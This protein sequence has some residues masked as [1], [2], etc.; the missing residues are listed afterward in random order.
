MTFE[1]PQFGVF[2]LDAGGNCYDAKADW[3][4]ISVNLTIPAGG[5]VEMERSLATAR[6]LWADQK[7]WQKRI[8]DCAIAELWELKNESWLG[9][10]EAEVTAAEFA[11]RMQLQTVSVDADGL[12]DFWH[13]DG[14]LFWGHVITVAG[15]LDDGPTGADIYG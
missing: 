15:S 6:N 7:N 3:G 13:H 11:A 12:F 10:D 9:E 14:E 1:D 4:G 5:P 8:T 2:T